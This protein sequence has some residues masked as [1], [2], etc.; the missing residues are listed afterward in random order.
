M[1]ILLKAQNI[2]N[3]LRQKGN[4]TKA[5]DNISFDGGSGEFVG[6]M[7][8]SGSGKTT[9]LNCVSTIDTVN[10]RAHYY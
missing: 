8:A 10:I 9:I 5:V 3:I 7:G 6:C 4:V 1:S 2:E